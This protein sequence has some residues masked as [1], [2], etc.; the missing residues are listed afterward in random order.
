MASIL[1]LHGLESGPHGNKYKS[2]CAAGHGV[3]APDTE[4]VTDLE[5]R[6]TAARAAL[7][8]MDAPVII[9]GSSYGGLT[10]CLL[11]NS[12]F[13]LPD[14]AAKV[15]GVVLLAPALHHGQ[16][17]PECHPKT[18]ILHGTQDEVVPLQT[19][20]DY[21]STHGVEVHRVDD[22]HPLANSHDVT[23]GL[24]DAAVGRMSGAV[25]QRSL[26]DLP[27]P[28]THGSPVR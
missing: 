28:P 23:L 21:G 6:T 27:S 19:S 25:A 4:G 8:S 2:L 26:D 15:G 22:E 14:L 20:L 12:I 5:E 1:F 10:A 16:S 13:A 18:V 9:V 24:I 3:T 7:D 17:L 11:W